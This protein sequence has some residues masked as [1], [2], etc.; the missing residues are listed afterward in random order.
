[1]KSGTNK[2]MVEI[3]IVSG[4]TLTYWLVIKT[5]KFRFNK[6]KNNPGNLKKIF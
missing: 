5:L 4:N 1:M 2:V 3:T 6:E